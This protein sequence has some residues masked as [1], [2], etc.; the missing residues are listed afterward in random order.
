[1]IDASSDKHFPARVQMDR[2]RDSRTRTDDRSVLGP[3]KR[4]MAQFRQEKS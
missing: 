2:N 4:T 1:M 3:N